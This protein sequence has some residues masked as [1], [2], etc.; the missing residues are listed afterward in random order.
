MAISTSDIK[1]LKPVTVTNTTANGGRKG[2]TEVQSGIRHSLF[3]RVTKSER[4][5]GVTRYRKIFWTNQNEDDDTAYDVLQ[6]LEVPSNGG[7]RF[8]FRKGTQTDTQGDIDD[9]ADTWTGCGALNAALSGGE[10]QIKLD[11]ENDDFVFVNGD[12]LHISDKKKTGQTVDSDV[13]AGDSV[14]YSA[15]SWSKIT[16]TDDIDYPN[17]IYLGSNVVLTLES[18]TNEEW[19]TIA[20]NLNTDESIGTGD[21][22]TSPTLSALSNATN[23][24]S[25]VAGQLPVVSTNDGVGSPGNSLTA[26]F[27]YDGSLDTSSSDASAGEID[28]TDGTWTAQITWDT[29]P[30]NGEDI[31]ITYRQKPYSYSGNTVTIDLEDTVTNAYTT[32]STTGSGCLYASEVVASTENW[33][34]TSGSGTYDESTYPVTA[35]NDGAEEDTIT[36]QFTGS[37]TFNVSGANMGSL[38]TGF[39]ISLDCTPSNPDNGKDVFTLDKD[40]WGGTWAT[41][42]TITF[43]LHPATDPGWLKEVVPAGTSQEPHNLT[44]LGWYAE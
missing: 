44:I 13:D 7:D 3:P 4:I 12:Y 37:S 41:N 21:G 25:I 9:S 36:I 34:E 2:Q 35:H 1:Y 43:D 8:Y 26:Y 11:M 5:N 18:G 20:E 23:G 32:A 30:G 24:I 27:N 14:T 10:S 42:D 15:G 40:G 31:T 39:S 6:W 29:A 22:T 28:M 17:G 38:G 19:V 16:A 33:A